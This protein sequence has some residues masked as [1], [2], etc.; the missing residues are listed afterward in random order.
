MYAVGSLK[1]LGLDIEKNA[2][3]QK[4]RRRHFVAIVTPMSINLT[5]LESLFNL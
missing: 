2:L 3:F 1:S 4:P 5:I